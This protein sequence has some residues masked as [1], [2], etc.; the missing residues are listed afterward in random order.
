MPAGAIEVSGLKKYF[1]RDTHQV[2][3]LDGID[4]VVREGE[5][6]ALMGPSGSGKTTLLNIIAGLD[7]PTAGQVTVGGTNIG[8]LSEKEL[9]RFRATQIGFVFQFYNLIPVLTAAENVEMPLLLTR[10][11]KAQ[12]RERVAT[13]LRIVGLDD[14]MHHLPRQLSGGEEQRVG[15]A[16][17]LVSDPRILLA[18]E[19][20]G[21]LDQRS[22]GEVMDLL[23]SLNRDLGRTIVMVTHDPKA[24]ARASH[25]AHLDKGVMPAAPALAASPQADR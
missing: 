13:A 7:R 15:I 6:L 12:R 1:T 5:F 21:D 9:T 23:V 18:D 10:L 8:A 25:V 22:A 2:R 3:A 16:R 11:P 24:A 19:P 14:R 20:T 17:A 4:L